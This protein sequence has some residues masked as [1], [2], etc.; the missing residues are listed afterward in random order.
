[1]ALYQSI[2]AYDRLTTAVS[3]VNLITGRGCIP[4]ISSPHSTG[5]IAIKTSNK[6][7]RYGKASHH[8]AS[9]RS[10]DRLLHTDILV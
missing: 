9:G 7:I 2:N 8:L 10:W 4:E 1:M 6:L 3:L 5:P